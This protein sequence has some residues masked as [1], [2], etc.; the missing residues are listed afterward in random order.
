MLH[1]AA[2]HLTH[3]AYV[4]SR[5]VSWKKPRRNT[6]LDVKIQPSRASAVTAEPSAVLLTLDLGWLLSLHF[7][8][9]KWISITLAPRGWVRINWVAVGRPWTLEPNRT[10]LNPSLAT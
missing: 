10:D 2:C 3:P 1:C 7:C 6:D 8:S 5:V 4:G 9:H